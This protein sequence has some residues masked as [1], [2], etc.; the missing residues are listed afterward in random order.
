MIDLSTIK[1]AFM[2]Y[3]YFYGSAPVGTQLPY[4]VGIGTDS[5]NFLADN[6]V[7]VKANGFQ[8]N[9]YSQTK[10]ETAEAE[11]ETILDSLGV[12]WDKLESYEADQSF[13]LIT[14]NFWR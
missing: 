9:Y 13:Y 7:Y 8:L 1:T 5:D 3:R 14:Y 2:S 6:K 4:L 11:I 12:I 10:S